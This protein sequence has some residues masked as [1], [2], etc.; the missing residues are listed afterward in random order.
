MK[1]MY[2]TRIT[3]LKVI[4][5]Y[6]HRCSPKICPRSHIPKH[7]AGPSLVTPY[8]HVGLRIMYSMS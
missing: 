6:V 1:C 5:Q 3:W 7:K 4:F 8:V 2:D